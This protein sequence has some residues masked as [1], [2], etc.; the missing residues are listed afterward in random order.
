MAIQLQKSSSLIALSFALVAGPL[1]GIQS[2]FLPPEQLPSE[3]LHYTNQQMTISVQKDI[4]G[5]TGNSPKDGAPA[6]TTPTTAVNP[7]IVKGSWALTI[8]A[9]TGERY[10]QT[11]LADS[12]GTGTFTMPA[13][14]KNG[15]YT[16]VMNGANL[17]FVD[18]GSGV[19]PQLSYTVSLNV[20]DKDSN[21]P[22]TPSSSPS[23]NE[24]VFDAAH[25]LYSFYFTI[26]NA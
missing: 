18:S 22:L 25:L 17:V 21:K 23:G 15:I 6:P 2:K 8:V 26:T 16:V 10:T 12:T 19:A 14:L 7:G 11:I 5:G 9:P 20:A 4:P 24:V 3:L 13:Q 1:F